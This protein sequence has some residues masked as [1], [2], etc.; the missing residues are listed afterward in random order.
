MILYFI[1]MLYSFMGVSIAPSPRQSFTM[2]LYDCHSY[3][4]IVRVFIIII[5]IITKDSRKFGVL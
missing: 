4:S 3:Y 2:A 1:G 5:V